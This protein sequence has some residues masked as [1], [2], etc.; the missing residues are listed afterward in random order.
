M[1]TS[2]IRRP[3][4]IVADLG[5]FA[6]RIRALGDRIEDNTHDAVRRTALAINQAVVLAT[7][8][9]T[10]R[11]RANWQVGIG[12]P[13]LGATED[14]DPG[15]GETVA[16]NN[17]VISGSKPEAEI[18]LTNNLP[19][20]EALNEGSSSQAPAGFVEEAVAVGA[21][22]AAQVRVVK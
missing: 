13:E 21:A 17:L 22:A 14:T 6:R 15:G 8:V 1:Y 12:E 9:D 4:A 19:Y 16:R 7:P 10:G 2:N 18:H 3:G 11:A 5:I 20:I